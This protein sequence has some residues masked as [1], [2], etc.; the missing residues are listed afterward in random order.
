MLYAQVDELTH[1]GFTGSAAIEAIKKVFAAAQK[2]L[3]LHCCQLMIS[4]AIRVS[5]ERGGGGG[6]GRTVAVAVVNDFYSLTGSCL[7][8]ELARFG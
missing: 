1:Y 5:C 7:F 4:R 3:L 6:Q 8:P 2:L